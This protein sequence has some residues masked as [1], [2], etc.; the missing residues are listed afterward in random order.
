MKKY[1]VLC[2]LVFLTL[3]MSACA[4]TVV[5][6]DR[7]TP[8]PVKEEVRGYPPC[9]GALWVPGHWQWRGRHR[10]HVWVPGHWRLH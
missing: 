7:R 5:V 9:R 10:G 3:G 1:C 6:Y 8:P 2:A 4:R